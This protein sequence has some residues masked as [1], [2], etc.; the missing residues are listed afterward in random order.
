[1]DLSAEYVAIGKGSIVHI[2]VRSP[3]N[4]CRLVNSSTEGRQRLIV[5]SPV[6]SG[7]FP[8]LPALICDNWQDCV[9]YVHTQQP[10]SHHPERQGRWALFIPNTL[11]S[12]L[13]VCCILSEL[14]LA[15]QQNILHRAAYSTDWS[16][17]TPSQT[18]GLNVLWT[19]KSN[20]GI[21]SKCQKD[22]YSKKKHFTRRTW[23]CL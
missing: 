22:M 3:K 18:P 21:W 10:D 13:W 14:L 1:M 7:V 16:T 19:H 2:Q 17:L 5:M 11:D 8:L 9:V 12:L 15:K 20:K 4:V 6:Y 23:F